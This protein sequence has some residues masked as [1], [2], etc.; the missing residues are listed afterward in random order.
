MILIFKK[1]L[2][3]E[4]KLKIMKEKVLIKINSEKLDSKCKT[5]ILL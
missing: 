5:S 1:L 4:L 3:L 2:D